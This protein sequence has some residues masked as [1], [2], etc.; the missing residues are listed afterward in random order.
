MPSAFKDM[1][2]KELK[3]QFD[4]NPYAFFSSFEKLSVADLSDLRANLAK[5]AAS[6]TLMV[7]HSFAKKIFA[8]K[9]FSDAEK[10]LQSATL[11]TFANRDPQVVSKALMDFIKT[12]AK[13]KPQGV[14]FENKVYDSSFVLRLSKLPSRHEL[15]TQVVVR[16]K[17]PLSG[18]AITLNQVLRGVVVA[19]NA[20]KEKKQAQATA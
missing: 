1:M 16:V 10:F 6:R 7:K 13:V 4:D 17:S 15:L 3:K 18:L 11:I 12:N 2:M 14:I 5:S 8:E 19:I 20:I 9:N